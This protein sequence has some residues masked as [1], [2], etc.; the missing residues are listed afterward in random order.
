MIQK[1]RFFVDEAF[2]V[3]WIFLADFSR[4]VHMDITYY[5]KR[6]YIYNTSKSEIQIT[7][8]LGL[9]FS[10]PVQNSVF[11][12]FFVKTNKHYCI[13]VRTRN[14]NSKSGNVRNRISFAPR[15]DVTVQ[16]KSSHHLASFV[17]IRFSVS[18]S[19]LS[20]EGYVCN[21][22]SKNWEAKRQ[23]PHPYR[24]RPSNNPTFD[25]KCACADSRRVQ[26]ELLLKPRS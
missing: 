12:F 22:L 23:L 24:T 15:Y 21:W 13:A 16:C 18:H 26:M 25:C 20:S 8:I 6:Y 5:E 2:P 11:F 7:Q 10:D 1:E 9:R 14:V 17:R 3:C 19:T 4:V